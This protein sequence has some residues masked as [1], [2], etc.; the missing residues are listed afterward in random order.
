LFFWLFKFTE[1]DGDD[2]GIVWGG[3]KDVRNGE[4]GCKF[5]VWISMLCGLKAALSGFGCYFGIVLSF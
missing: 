4:W 2:E 5:F 1:N 3:V